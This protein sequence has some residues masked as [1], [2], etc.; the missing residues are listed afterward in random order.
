MIV[1]KSTKYIGI[2]KRLLGTETALAVARSST[3]RQLNRRAREVPNVID[4]FTL[5]AA[6]RNTQ[7]KILGLHN[8]TA[9]ITLLL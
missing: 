6:L 7:Q 2:I 8:S 5:I 4:C 1:I 3:L 9:S